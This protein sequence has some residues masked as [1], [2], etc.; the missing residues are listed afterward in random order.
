MKGAVPKLMSGEVQ[1]LHGPH[2]HIFLNNINGTRFLYI[3]DNY[4]EDHLLLNIRHPRYFQLHGS[5]P[6]FALCIHACLD[7][8]PQQWNGTA[9]P[10]NRTAYSPDLIPHDC[11]TQGMLK[12]HVY[13]SKPRD[14]QEF[15]RRN[16]SVN[17]TKKKYQR[18]GGNLKM[19][20]GMC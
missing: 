17:T 18:Y 20:P 2:N 15:Q 11:W 9:G 12:E 1:L 5:S 16:E 13:S 3:P 19:V 4:V 7:K 8:F 6:H 14:A 10:L